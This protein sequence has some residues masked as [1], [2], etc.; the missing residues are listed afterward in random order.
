MQRRTGAQIVVGA[1]T[2]C[3]SSDVGRR[4]AHVGIVE[5][6]RV[7]LRAGRVGRVQRPIVVE[8]RRRS[9]VDLDHHRL[10]YRHVFGH[11]HDLDLGVDL[12][13]DDDGRLERIGRHHR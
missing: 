6:A 3:R 2:G 7:V 9:I 10:G 8:R 13:V 1:R 4:S 5:V 12:D 11:E